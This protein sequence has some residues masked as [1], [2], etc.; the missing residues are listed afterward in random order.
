MMKS[1][2]YQTEKASKRRRSERL[3]KIERK[4]KNSDKKEGEEEMRERRE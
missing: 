3:K 1:Q 4:M 2:S